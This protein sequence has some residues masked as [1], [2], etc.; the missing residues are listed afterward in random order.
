MASTRRQFLEHAGLAG[1]G[2]AAAACR[3]TPKLPWLL[4]KSTP[5][6]IHTVRPPGD[7]RQALA[8]RVLK[9]VTYGPRPGDLER[10][11][12][13]GPD[14]FIEEQLSPDSIADVQAYWLVRR[15]ETIHLSA[16]DIF[17]VAAK[18]AIGDLR[19]ATL[20]R[21]LYSERQLRERMVEFWSDHFNIYVAKGECAWLKV[22]DD[23]EV[24]RRHALGNFRDLLAASAKSPAMLT[25]LDGR[26]NL[27]GRPNENHAR[28]IL[29]LHT[30]GVNGGYT[31][32]DVSE[33]ARALTGW[34][35]RTV[36]QRG[37]A[38]L[39]PAAHDEGAKQV[40]GL[41]LASDAARDLD[42][43][44]DRLCRHP[45]TARFVSRKL[46]RRFVADD[47]PE[48]LVARAAEAFARSGGDIRA[49]LSTVLH[50]DELRRSAPLFQRPYA[51][52][53]SALRGLSAHS[54]GGPALQR[55]LAAMGQL[56]F[57]WPT[58]DGYPDGESRWSSQMLPRW[59][60]ALA[61]AGNR[62]AG[63]RWDFESAPAPQ[64][65]AAM[66][67]GR[68]LSLEERRAFGAVDSGSA[69]VALALCHPAFQYS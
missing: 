21:A 5:P 58:P 18:T 38:F 7:A 63:T 47:P 54:D 22:I 13:I 69:A 33:L 67:V 4:G 57:D 35:V 16:P 24:I 2:V 23:R 56:P 30:L 9:R 59:N 53:L 48:S 55:H 68:E 37:R 17:D 1:I 45:S 66:L 3:R 46:C 11:D 62:I 6:V 40:L 60:F 28:E 27:R 15:V 42:Q 14:A 39:E 52:G 65:L 43:V 44:I 25:Y 12:H 61:L 50:S 36:W 31:Q 32:R 20:L 8:V 26:S 51:Y 10:V 34:R 19:R 41:R 49:V 29:E 64:A